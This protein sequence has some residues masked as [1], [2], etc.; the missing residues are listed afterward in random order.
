M[1]VAGIPLGEPPKEFDVYLISYGDNKVAIAKQ[2][3][4]LR[5]G[6]GLKTVLNFENCVIWAGVRG[7]IAYMTQAKI[8]KLGGEVLIVDTWKHERE[9][10]YIERYTENYR[11]NRGRYE[12][13]G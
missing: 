3:R 1:Y 12:E 11:K 5:P 10:Y 13:L 8:K 6:L 9:S 7:E 4:V 2:L